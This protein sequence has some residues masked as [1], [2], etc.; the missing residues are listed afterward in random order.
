MKDLADAFPQ[1]REY[2][3]RILLI[4]SNLLDYNY[5]NFVL[6]LIPHYLLIYNSY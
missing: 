1:K 6:W 2:R 4:L 3:I 5:R